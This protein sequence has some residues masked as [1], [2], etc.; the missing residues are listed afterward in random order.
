MSS[1]AAAAPPVNT[2]VPIYTHAAAGTGSTPR[3][4]A[5]RRAAGTESTPRAAASAGAAAVVVA[6][7]SK[8]PGA[9]RPLLAFRRKARQPRVVMQAHAEPVDTIG[10]VA[11]AKLGKPYDLVVIGGGP[12]GV[13]A[14][15]KTALLGRRVLL[16]DKP[17]LPPN[18]EG[19]DITFGGP[20]GLWSKALRDTAKRIDVAQLRNMGLHD[21]A[22]WQDIVLS[23]VDLATGNAS[24]QVDV[25][26]RYKVD[27]LQATA[28]LTKSNS[29]IVSCT[30]PDGR[31]CDVQTDNVLVATGSKP[32]R[33][34]FM[35][36]DDVRV[37][38][39]D[40]INQLKFLPNKVCIAGAGIIAVEYAKIFRK[41][42][43]QV[44]LM[45]RSKSL[46]A[47]ERIGLDPDIANALI[48]DLVKDD[49]AIYEGAEVAKFDVPEAG[50]PGD[51]KLTMKYADWSSGPDFIDCDVFLAA[52][53]RRPNTAF[54]EKA[55]CELKKNGGVKVD[56][57]LQTTV[58]GIFA[59]GDALG[60]YSLCST[61]E[62]EADF[63][64]E[65]MFDESKRGGEMPPFPVGMW[66]VPEV[67][68]YGLTKAAAEEKGID[69]EEGVAQYS[70]CLR[71]RV[72]SPEGFLKLVFRKDNGEIVGVHMIG[73]DGCEMVHYGMDLVS[74]KTTIFKVM[75]TIF[76]AVTFHELFKKAAFA[77][78]ERL[79]FGVE[80][81][82]IFAEMNVSGLASSLAD[83]EKAKALFHSIDDNGN[84]E[85]DEEELG[86]FF[87]ASGCPLKPR[88]LASL[89]RL[90]D[91]DGSGTI[92]WDEF[93]EI[94][95][96]VAKVEDKKVA[97]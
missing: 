67:G 49:V 46:T 90:S 31:E 44:T 69:V 94:A 30:M 51:V 17:K 38:D 41:L 72:F 91:A 34:S 18:G 88:T 42:G 59:C 61:G 7:A 47:L 35:P 92:D 93:S 14:A 40:T 27:Y 75:T 97:A 6:F 20:T 25:L 23:C 96:I 60:G 9:L 95:D 50:K 79:K 54:L 1:L 76:T 68:T 82:S 62:F 19:L 10:Y 55:G 81:T 65:R 45:V 11:T 39:S 64:V 21:E 4:S 37:F 63:A 12:A 28:N 48:D 78:N 29:Q 70:D 71:G 80:W 58:P 84:G 2:F 57:D 73:A 52:T 15:I 85:L 53:G 26:K 56:A 16:V 3:R 22:I 77:G 74:T 86:R 13:A 5:P 66:T 89:M 36:F 83:T 43:A 8:V 32:V 33:L 24:V 87:E